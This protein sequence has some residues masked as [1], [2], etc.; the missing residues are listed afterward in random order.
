M[1]LIIEEQILDR[2]VHDITKM[3]TLLK[4]CEPSA[5]GNVLSACERDLQDIRNDLLDALDK[6]E[7]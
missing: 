5:S 3:I 7:N 1:L 6:G 4:T 2:V